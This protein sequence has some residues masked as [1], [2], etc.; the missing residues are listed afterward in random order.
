MKTITT[1]VFAIS[2]LSTFGQGDTLYQSTMH[3]GID[4][5]YILYVPESYDG[6]EAWP[7]VINLHGYAI[8]AELQMT[9]SAMNPVADTGNFLVVYPEGDTIVSTAPN[10][11]PKGLG[12][13][14][15]FPG[16]T[17]NFVSPRN[18][19]DV[20]FI[21]QLIDLLASNYNVDLA[22]VFSTGWSNG[23]LMSH[24]LACELSGRI[25][26]IAPVAGTSVKLRPCNSDRQVPVLS[27]H[28]TKDPIVPYTYPPEEDSI[29]F[30]SRV[31]DFLNFWAGVNGC[32]GDTTVTLLPDVVAEDTST[33]ELITWDSCGVEMLHYRVVDGGHNWPGG[34]NIFPFLGY[35]N[36]DINASSEIWNFFKRNPHPS[37]SGQV[38]EKMLVHN[39][40]LRS[41]LLYVP[42]AYD[43]SKEWPLVINYHG[44]TNSAFDQMFIS[45]MNPVADTANFLVAYPQGL[46]VDNPFAG[47]SSYG[48]NVFDTLSNNDDLDFT[49]KLIDHINTDYSLDPS[50]VYAT[51]W[52]MGANMAL[53]LSCR[54]PDRIASVAGVAGRFAESQ[55]DICNP[56]R[57]FSALLIHGTTDPIDSFEGD[58]VLFSAVP[59]SAT[60][61]ADLNNCAADT[62]VTEF[63]DLVETDSSTV[64]QV[65]YTT[66]DANTEVLYYR[67]NGGGHAWPGGGELPAF[68]GNVNRDINASSEIWNFFNRHSLPNTSTSNEDLLNLVRKEISV[69]PNPFHERLQIDLDLIQGQ[70]VQLSLMD[71]MGQSV[72]TSREFQ[73]ASG[74]QVLDWSPGNVDLASGMYYLR[75]KLGEQQSLHPVIF[76]VR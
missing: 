57:P 54:L 60:F 21:N 64:T 42:A 34:V 19:D 9:L 75:V 63:P 53:I 14:V 51:G 45:Q 74:A 27:I 41:Y 68:L 76:Q 66:C 72:S 25:A 2:L 40:T 26:A 56:G 36:E 65:E 3:G 58:G 4:R 15:S 43:G 23:G 69:Y 46:I 49:S 7:L 59:N 62:V 1:L 18:T 44:F 47:F 39:D 6:T 31:P 52:S 71:L 10:T 17:V 61:F 28:G 70:R 32:N 73:L 13:N 30:L 37:P 8:T 5:N 22:R 48:W 35:F 11:P 33:V 24:V 29:N 67:I 20:G 50:Q 38:F 55:M 16:D 12:F